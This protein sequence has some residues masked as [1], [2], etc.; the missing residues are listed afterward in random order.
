MLKITQKKFVSYRL[1]LAASCALGAP[2][3][4]H[5]ARDLAVFK[6]TGEKFYLVAVGPDLLTYSVP[7]VLLGLAAGLL[8]ALQIG[9]SQIRSSNLEV[10]KIEADLARC[11]EQ[12]QQEYE[13]YSSLQRNL[14]HQ[15]S[16]LDARQVDLQRGWLALGEQ[17]RAL[18]G[19]TR[20]LAKIAADQ[21]QKHINKQ[22]RGDGGNPNPKP[23]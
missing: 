2:F 6:R 17:E 3:F 15:K 18:E 5:V 8:A 19:K 4:F 21:Q 9:W 1:H 10:A 16:K 23:F 11:R 22:R 13:K 7:L 14:L 12:S 20:H